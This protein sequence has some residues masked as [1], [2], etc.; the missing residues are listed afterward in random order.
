MAFVAYSLYDCCDACSN[1]NINLASPNRCIALTFQSNL[2]QAYAHE[3]PPGGA[4]CYLKNA[5][6]SG[7]TGE[8]GPVIGAVMQSS[9]TK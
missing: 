3:F 8:V 4:N 7:V 1:M 9:S 2:S 5:S 6:D